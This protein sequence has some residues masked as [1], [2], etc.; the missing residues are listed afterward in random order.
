M[1]LGSS[2]LEIAFLH[3]CCHHRHSAVPAVPVMYRTV[4]SG[5]AAMLSMLPKPTVMVAFTVLPTVSITET[6]LV[7]SDT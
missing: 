4:P 5:L 7:V 3:A 1:P 6:L 2:A